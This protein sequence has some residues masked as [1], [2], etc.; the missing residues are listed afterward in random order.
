ML[1]DRIWSEWLYGKCTFQHKV[2]HTPTSSYGVIVLTCKVP[3]LF[4]SELAYA[5][6][7]TPPNTEW[8]PV[9]ARLQ[10]KGELKLSNWCIDMTSGQTSRSQLSL[11]GDDDRRCASHQH[12]ERLQCTAVCTPHPF[13]M[14]AQWALKSARVRNSELIAQCPT[15]ED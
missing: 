15:S 14:S 4:M 6:Q 8:I 3:S 5:T 10:F 13:D 7:R 1:T 2:S 9:S 12:R 11:E